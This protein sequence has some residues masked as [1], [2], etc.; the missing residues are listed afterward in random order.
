MTN[1]VSVSHAFKREV[2]P[3]AKKYLTLRESVDRLI[4]D[5]IKDPY[6][7]ED[8]GHGLFKV[9]LSD[10]SKGK[11]KRGGFRVMYYHLNITKDKIDVLLLSIYNKSEQSTIKKSDALKRLKGILDEYK[12]ESKQT[13]S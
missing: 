2:K 12:R 5:L 4:E 13:K 3:L 9:R 11:G 6:L 7:G 10:E 1:T 8:Y